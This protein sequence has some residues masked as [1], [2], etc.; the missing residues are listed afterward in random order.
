VNP[1]GKNVGYQLQL[2]DATDHDSKTDIKSEQKKT[3]DIRQ[4]PSL[5]AGESLCGVHFRHKQ[6]GFRMPNEE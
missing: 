3:K 5:E 1:S 2:E 4:R 6:G